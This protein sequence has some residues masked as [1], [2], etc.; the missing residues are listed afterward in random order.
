M[1]RGPLK[2]GGFEHW[3][4]N[5]PDLA[6]KNTLIDIIR[7]GAKIGYTGPPQ[8]I[9]TGN[10]ASVS[11]APDIL[12]SEIAKRATLKQIE[13]IPAKNLPEKFISS[14][15]SLTPKSGGRWRRIHNLSLPHGRSVND[16]IPRE[17]GSLRFA[18]FDNAVEAIRSAGPGATLIKRD[19]ADAYRHI[20]VHPEDWWLLGFCWQGRYWYDQFLPFGL[21]TSPI[22]FD[23]FSSALEWILRQERSWH[24]TLHYLDDFLGIMPPNG[25]ASAFIR[26]FDSICADLGFKINQEKN[27]HGTRV[28]FLGI[29]IDT[30]AMEA[31]LP[32]EKRGK[33]TA[34][35]KA[36]LDK[37]EVSYSDLEAL[38]GR[39]AF[40]AGIA[41][42]TRPL[43][44]R[45][46]DLLGSRNSGSP[47]TIT[48]EAREDLL[49]WS[50]F[51][52]KWNGKSLL[53]PPTKTLRIW[54]D[55]S[56]TGGI[57]GHF[58]RDGQR[59]VRS[60][61]DVSQMFR[62][63]VPSNNRT[64]SLDSKKLHAV[65]HAFSTWE[66]ELRRSKVILHCDSATITDAMRKNKIWGPAMAPLRSVAMLI[67]VNHIT[68]E[69]LCIPTEENALAGALSKS[70]DKRIADLCP[71]LKKAVKNVG[72]DTSKI[73]L[74]GLLIVED[75]VKVKPKDT[76]K[77]QPMGTSKA[78][79]SVKDTVKVALKDTVKPASKDTAKPAP[80]DTAKPA[81]KDTAK[82]ASK[83]TAKPAPKDTAKPAPKDTAKIPQKEPAK[84]RSKS[85]PKEGAKKGQKDPVNQTPKDAPKSP[86]V[87]D[88]VKV[89]LKDAPK[90]Q[91]V[92][93]TVKVTLKDVVKSPPPVKDKPK[94]TRVQSS[95]GGW[96]SSLFGS[97]T[98]KDT[99]KI[100]L[101]DRAN[102]TPRDTANHTPKDAAQ[103]AP[104][105]TAESPSKNLPKGA[106]KHTPKDTVKSK[107]P[108]KEAVAD[109]PKDPMK[110]RAKDAA[111]PT[112]KDTAKPAPED[113]AKPASKD[114]KPAPKDTKPA[115]T[116]TAKPAPKDTAEIPQKEQA[117]SRSKSP[118]KE[119]AKKG[120]KDPVNQ[121]PK[122]AAKNKPKN[123]AKD[124]PQNTA[125][126]A[127]H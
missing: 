7:F 17:W 110:Q 113:T 103:S 95:G 66:G 47:I 8:H 112:P 109:K 52:Q 64:E 55:A 89:T 82:P 77:P 59:D 22:I 111:K 11:K 100:P 127:K 58:M 91:T 34:Q 51:L 80:K 97:A 122:D 62:E 87:K 57:G 108:P 120:Q 18:H 54:I 68:L 53:S 26:D 2:P 69:V 45:L 24:L 94:D 90:S 14:P 72:K 70:D 32:Q 12:T 43:L 1:L 84:S 126:K 116:D 21:R 61:P 27:Q 115:P 78:P 44:R 23:Q 9:I 33:A 104:K 19:L 4:R 71:Q 31:R 46:Y 98:P 15:L 40:A 121:T 65:A 5:H 10:A 73:I 35:V 101:R 50:S 118:P 49:W 92:K 48:G 88:T 13:E 79:P 107:T 3:L 39:L 81:P 28:T 119:G 74:K 6:Y 36:V 67:A 124:G 25:K 96:L 16:H 42:D 76:T 75:P 30:I 29:E 106:T 125:K 85:P 63:R 102:S 56:N 105:D 114:T 123:T 86:T 117:K 38:V 60:Y 37:P 99:P 93:D 83:D 20:P 41:P